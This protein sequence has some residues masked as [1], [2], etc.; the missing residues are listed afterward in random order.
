MFLITSPASPAATHKKTTRIAGGFFVGGRV[1]YE[2]IQKTVDGSH[3]T[4]SAIYKCPQGCP[5]SYQVITL[6]SGLSSV[7]GQTS[8]PLPC[9]TFPYY[10]KQIRIPLD[11]TA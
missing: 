5:H 10:A 6:S 7:P 11:R 2:R 9:L 8:K 4:L 1:S 3:S